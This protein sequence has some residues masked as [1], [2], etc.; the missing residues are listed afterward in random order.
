MN[1]EQ[2]EFQ[3]SSMMNDEA[4][5]RIKQEAAQFEEAK[6]I[7]GVFF[8]DDAEI[9]LRDGKTYKI[10]PCTLK[11][12]RKLMN[13]LKTVSIDAIILNFLP[14]EEAGDDEQ[15]ENDLF[16]ILAMAFK[17]YPHVDRDYIDE[18]VDLATAREIIEIMIG[19]NG[20]KK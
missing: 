4:V 13:L 15:R 16:D 1:K 8:E 11:D 20:L 6:R 19:L 10:P 18:N 7:E 5:A 9:K 17:G 12:A 14:P 2:A 3:H